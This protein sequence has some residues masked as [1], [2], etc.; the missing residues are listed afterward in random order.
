MAWSR[1]HG[2]GL[3]VLVSTGCESKGAGGKVRAEVG[4]PD[5]PPVKDT[6]R[7]LTLRYQP[8]AI[9]GYR[10][11]TSVKSLPDSDATIEGGMTM[12]FGFARGPAARTREARVRAVRLDMRTAGENVSMRTDGGDTLVMGR[13]GQTLR[14]KRG[15]QDPFN[16]DQFFDEPIITLAFTADNRVTAERNPEHPMAETGDNS[17]GNLL[18][19]FPDLPA[20][21]LHAG[22]RWT[23][24]RHVSLGAAMDV[25]VRFRLSLLGQGGCPSGR[26][27]CAVVDVEAG[28]TTTSHGWPITYSFAGRLYFDDE[29]GAVD[30]MRLHLRLDARA[31]HE[32][33]ILAADFAMSATTR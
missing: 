25:D 1:W 26:P 6:S 5:A 23:V 15:E 8:E 20:H 30:E 9:G 11:V 22:D 2:L 18:V 28:D 16:V 17:I 33:M 32:K 27:A 12:E 4:W 13:N 14:A 21:E 7:A 19:V 24:D 31:D 10:Y 29:L 3:V